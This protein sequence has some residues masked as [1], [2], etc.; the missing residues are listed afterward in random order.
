MVSRV[1]LF[2]GPIA[3]LALS[4]CSLLL[5]AASAPAAD[6]GRWSETGRSTI[7]LNYYQGITSDPQSNLYFDGVYTGLYRT[8]SELRET[9]RNDDV[10]PPTVTLG[11]R[12][13]H[14]G[15]I[16]WDA[17]EGGRI[18]LPLEC[19]Y[20]GTPNG[21]NSCG[22]GSIGV[23][24][25]ATVQWRYY[26][27]LDP[28]DIAKAM[29]AEAS[30]DGTELWTSSGR[31]LLAYRM[32]EITAANAAPSGRLLRPVR[33]LRGAVPPSGITGATFYEDGRLYVAG[34]G[35]GPFQVYSIDLA[36]GTSRLEIEREIVG[37][38]EGLDV[39]SSL[40]GVLHWQI[41][42]YNEG[43]M[44]TYGA[45]NGTLL[46]F[47]PRAA[48]VTDGDADGVEDSRDNCPGVPNADQADADGDAQGDLCDLDDDGDGVADAS[49]NCAGAP[50]ADQANADGDA[51]GNACD[52]DDDN[53]GVADG[54][55]GCPLEAGG[56][57]SDG[58]PPPVPAPVTGPSDADA[59][60]VADADDN[61][62]TS[63]NADQADADGD[64]A[65][66]MCDA[67][68]DNDG[69]VDTADNCRTTAN[70][71]QAGSD[72]DAAGDACDPDDDNDGRVDAGDSCP[73]T[74]NF[75][76]ADG[77]RDGQGDACD[78]DPDGDLVVGL[79]DRCPNE[80][81]AAGT[82]DGCPAGAPVPSDRDRDGDRIPDSVESARGT[83]PLDRDTDDDGMA[84]GGEDRDRDG[85]LDRGETDPLRWD[86]DRDRLSDGLE[87]G[88]RTPV[89]DPLGPVRG[90][91][92][93]RFRRDR[94]PRSRTNPMSADT[95]RD[96]LRDGAEDRNRNGRREH[97]ETDPRRAD[98]D[99]DR[100]R[101][102]RDRR[103]L[104]PAG[105]RA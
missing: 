96:R 64:G 69:I 89:A 85:V 30:P 28:R 54:S 5:A 6:P 71:D 12:Y 59:D 74:A 57:R 83:S 68:D 98:T 77:D 19:Y 20:P 78:A 4:C 105:R 21:G 87:R 27:K 32:A 26:V 10:I 100:F 42:P 34:Q 44:P 13:N 90:T 17:M 22:T 70:P 23:A 49:D 31:D 46:H 92:R 36:T 86:S 43:E 1:R 52:G 103:P 73:V 11:E 35:A 84:D 41:Q 88:R 2:R 47:V 94:D 97:R 45:T 82:A 60:G 58:C 25:P 55:D 61:C 101:D 65:G 67:D 40:G 37:E 79:D 81:G 16:T 8:D 104:I 93:R 29:W 51:E 24:D 33:R 15:D 50:N 80:P 53:D 3:A 9:A 91:D 18:L 56:G 76:Q 48:G 14:I 66:D 63:A 62:R 39:F 38:S 72:A 75:D 95:D 102:G 99:G 7:P